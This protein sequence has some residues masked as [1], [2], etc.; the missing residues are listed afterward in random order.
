MALELGTR[1]DWSIGDE[2]GVIVIRV[3]P[4]RRQRLA[5]VQEIGQACRDLDLQR[6][7]QTDR[8]DVE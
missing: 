5:R 1:L 8:E 7:L 4:S 2:P 3:Q 6:Q